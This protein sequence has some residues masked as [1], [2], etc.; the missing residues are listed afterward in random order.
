MVKPETHSVLSLSPEG[1][2]YID[3]DDCSDAQEI[4]QKELEK[5]LH[6]FDGGYVPGLLRLGLLNNLSTLPSSFVFWQKFAQRFITEICK[7][8][9]TSNIPLLPSE[10]DLQ[11]FI[12]QAPFMKGIEY[13]S[14]EM[15]LGLWKD[16][17]SA[18]L[19]ELKPFN[20]NLQDYLSTYNAAWNLLG[21]VCFHL[22]ENKE[23]EAMPFAFLATYTS[24]LSQNSQ[25]QHLPLGRALQEYA[26]EKNKAALLALLFPV[27]KAS[28]QSDLIKN[29][30]DSGEIF[31][32]LAWKV[33]E[34]H[35]F[36]KDIPL[37][38]S[39][40]IV[41]RVPNWWNAKK[42]PRPQ[43]KISIGEEQKSILGMNTL[44]NFNSKRLKKVAFL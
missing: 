18:L 40:G 24:K 30:V 5:I 4:S 19:L 14:I 22:A 15:L 39:A 43:I 16:L 36:L 28:Q 3:A 33:S 29:L 11:E 27:Q 42:P 2:L 13:L 6:F 23:N 34:A 35:R 12:V 26:G 7:L 21:R 10:T 41:V 9:D 25:A 37:F 20:G 44:L 17:Y 8:P 38:E 31:Q 32:P 1:H